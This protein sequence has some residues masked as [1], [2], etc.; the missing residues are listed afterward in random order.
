M[1]DQYSKPVIAPR[2]AEVSASLQRAEQSRLPNY[3]IRLTTGAGQGSGLSQELP[4]G[5]VTTFGMPGY[6]LGISTS[7]AANHQMEYTLNGDRIIRRQIAAHK[8][9]EVT[10]VGK[11]SYS[12]SFAYIASKPAPGL[13]LTMGIFEPEDLARTTAELF[14]YIKSS[15]D[16]FDFANLNAGVVYENCEIRNF[17]L[18]RSTDGNRFGFNY[19]LSFVAYGSSRGDIAS[20]GVNRVTY[21]P[22]SFTSDT[23]IMAKISAF[24]RKVTALNDSLRN[25]RT[26]LSLTVSEAIGSFNDAVLE[27]SRIVPNIF[28]YADTAR[29]LVGQVVGAWNTLVDA[30]LSTYRAIPNGIETLKNAFKD[31]RGQLI[32]AASIFTQSDD[33]TR[34]AFI[35]TW[36][37]YGDLIDDPLTTIMG[38]AEQLTSQSQALL[39]A[40]GPGAGT[41]GQALNGEALNQQIRQT[42]SS[43]TFDGGQ[44]RAVETSRYQ[45]RLGE[46][47]FDVA[48]KLGDVDSWREI[49]RVNNWL[50]PFHKRDGSPAKAGDFIDVPTTL[51]G[52]ASTALFAGEPSYLTDLTLTADGDIAISDVDVKL[53]SGEQNMEQALTSRMRTKKGELS[54]APNYGMGDLIG[55][56]GDEGSIAE[57]SV[58]LAEQLLSDPRVLNVSNMVSSFSDNQLD[59]Q[60]DVSLAGLEQLS[61]SIPII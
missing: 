4:G 5:A 3:L 52:A 58:D 14:R 12:T 35:D 20:K 24:N 9:I 2:P 7:E 42:R 25:T 28:A 10:V 26:R 50:D 47:L 44:S 41:S 54:Y 45:L 60:L 53:V 49:A 39:G 37:W 30:V 38:D 8:P 22:T 51:S 32:G 23:G 1:A 6:V 46:S 40:I 55:S 11:I 48:S 59:V 36:A 15:A 16:R 61:L 56:V 21:V 31:I 43:L 29:F 13:S 19:A 34:Q 33:A 27:L 18:D 57:L 17:Q